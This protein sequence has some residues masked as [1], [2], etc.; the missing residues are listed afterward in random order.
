MSHRKRKQG[1]GDKD[2]INRGKNSQ[3]EKEE[4]LRLQRDLTLLSSQPEQ[5][6]WKQ[7]TT[8]IRR[9]RMSERWGLELHRNSF[10]R[11]KREACSP[12]LLYANSDGYQ[13]QMAWVQILALTHAGVRS[14]QVFLGLGLLTC[15][16]GIMARLPHGLL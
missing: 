2:S 16:M 6:Q 3:E 15:K 13:T 5:N 12:C 8:R 9:P 7:T 4:F 10:Q 1:R 14:W 11:E